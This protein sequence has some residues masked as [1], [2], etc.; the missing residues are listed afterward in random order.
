MPSP[1][2]RTLLVTYNHRCQKCNRRVVQTPRQCA[3]QATR[4]HVIPVCMGGKSDANNVTLFCF[5]CNQRGSRAL[6]RLL[7]GRRGA[8]I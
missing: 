5:E 4:E 1:T 3:E 7:K 8:M 2:I 6:N